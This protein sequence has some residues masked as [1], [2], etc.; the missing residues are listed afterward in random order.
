MDVSET[1][2]AAYESPEVRVVGSVEELTLA[3]KV[4]T[5]PSD[6]TYSTGQTFNLS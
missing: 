4:Q 1:P 3:N 6:Y 5:S 2:A